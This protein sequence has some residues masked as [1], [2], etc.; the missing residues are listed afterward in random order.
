MVKLSDIELPVVYKKHLLFKAGE[1]NGLKISS[2]EVNKSPSNTKW[3]KMNESLIYSHKE[4]EAEAWVGKVKNVYAENGNTYGDVEFWDAQTALDVKYAQAP[5]AISAGIAWSEEYENPT[6]FFYRNFSLVSDPGVRDKEVFFNFTNNEKTEGFKTASF[7]SILSDEKEKMADCQK[8][9][10]MKDY[11]KK[12]TETHPD[13]CEC[14]EC[15]QEIKDE[16]KSDMTK[17]SNERRSSEN[18]MQNDLK[19]SEMEKRIEVMEARMAN[20]EADSTKVDEPTPSKEDAN[21][22]IPESKPVEP[23]PIPQAPAMDAAM[24]E[25]VVTKVVDKLIPVLKPAPMTVPE[26]NQDLKDPET[27]T[28]E[29]IANSLKK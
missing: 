13:N 7:S 3:N 22:P 12:P 23:T 5:F 1:W 20:F 21:V 25:N 14:E 26:F 11:E 15:K 2:F 8:C 18:Y 24:V 16:S 17:E 27:E 29:R 4:K 19:L 10:E 9:G 28:I 6:N